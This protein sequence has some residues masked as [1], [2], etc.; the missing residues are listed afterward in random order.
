MKQMAREHEDVLQNI[1]FALV[2]GHRKDPKIDDSK[3]DAALA[4]SLAGVDPETIEDILVS[5]LVQ[6][7]AS[8]RQLREDVP[9][10][11]W[12]EGLRVVKESVR[13]H[14]DLRPGKTSYFEFVKEYIK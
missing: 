4:A 2:S 8:I 7:L 12:R 3:A 9:E 1:E 10:D 6:A 13:R 5:D 11:I 14:S